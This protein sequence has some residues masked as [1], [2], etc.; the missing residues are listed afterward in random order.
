MNNP[1]LR[2]A[3]VTTASF[4]FVITIVS[5]WNAPSIGTVPPDNNVSAPVTISA[6]DQEK[7]G[8]LTVASL[9]STGGIRAFGRVQVGSTTVACSATVAGSLRWTGSAFEGCNGT[10]WTAFGGSTPP[11][12]PPP[13]PPP[14]F[15]SAANLKTDMINHASSCSNYQTIVGISP[16]TWQAGATGGEMTSSAHGETKAASLVYSMN[17]GVY[18]DTYTIQTQYT[19]LNG[20]YVFQNCNGSYTSTYDGGL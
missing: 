7:F 6:S 5:A 19:C 12:P 20:V 4:I 14:T 18:M 8:G 15:C 9:L 1:I 2:N 3:L 11:P 16:A 10:E 13:P 17:F